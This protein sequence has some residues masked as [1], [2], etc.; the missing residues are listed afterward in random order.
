MA[1]P[2]KIKDGIRLSVVIP[3]KQA[4]WLKKMA[5]HM[6]AQQGRQITVSEAIRLAIEQC[7]PLVE[8]Q[9]ELF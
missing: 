3:E 6:S 5:I 7:Y 8:K 1:R 9:L 2:K 4:N